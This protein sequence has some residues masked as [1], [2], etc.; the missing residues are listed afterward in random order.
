[1]F[2]FGH[3]LSYTTFKYKNLRIPKRIKAGDDINISVKVKN[4]GEVAGDEVVQLYIKDMEAS[5]IVPIR[6]LQ[7]IKR[8]H[9]KPGEEQKVE[10]DLIPK[11]I[12]VINDDA[13]F[14]VEPGV[15]EISVGG[16]LPGAVPSSTDVVFKTLQVKGEPYF[17]E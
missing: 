3:G 15:F 8:I 5:A 14:I 7:G 12:A 16:G 1:M 13:H 17:I 9:L 11:Q 2:A 6:S 4:T 10:F